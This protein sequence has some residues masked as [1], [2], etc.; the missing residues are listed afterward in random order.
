MKIMGL[1]KIAYG[2]SIDGEGMGPR[3]SLRAC[4]L[5]EEVEETT[6]RNNQEERRKSKRVS[7]G[8]RE[9]NVSERVKGVN[10]VEC[11]CKAGSRSLWGICSVARSVPGTGDIRN[12]ALLYLKSLGSNR[13]GRFVNE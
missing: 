1:Y 4:Q 5:S 11:C 3:S 12:Q 6:E 7:Y 9:K 2:G 10:S 8:R 13:G